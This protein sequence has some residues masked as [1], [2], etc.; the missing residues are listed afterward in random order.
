MIKEVKG[1]LLLTECKT[2]AHCVAPFDHFESGLALSLRKQYPGMAK[3]FR[4]YCQVHHPKAGNIWSWG[5]VGG[6]QIVNLMAQEPAESIHS[7]G[8]PGKATLSNLDKSLKY[9]AEWCEQEQVDKIALPKLATGVGGLEW[10]EVNQVIHK[11]LGDLSTEVIV[12]SQY[13]PGEKA[14]E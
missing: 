13:E 12:Y 6:R 1:D 3:D 14:E 8:H 2:I 5:G 4:H 9:L 10:E 7:K 11:R